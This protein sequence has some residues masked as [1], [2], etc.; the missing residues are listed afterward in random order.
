MTEGVV[1]HRSPHLGHIGSAVGL[2][3]GHQNPHDVQQEEKIDG[4]GHQHGGRYEVEEVGGLRPACP[5][6][7]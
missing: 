2:Q 6:G 1:S 3:F 5:A 7:V 4:V